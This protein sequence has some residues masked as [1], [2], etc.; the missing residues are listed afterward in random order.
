[1][2]VILNFAVKEQ[3]VAIGAGY[4]CLRVAPRCR[5]TKNPNG[6]G[7]QAG[8]PV[9]TRGALFLHSNLLTHSELL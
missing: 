5:T 7:L 6:G 1:M 4:T 9:S 2:I 3:C 8:Y